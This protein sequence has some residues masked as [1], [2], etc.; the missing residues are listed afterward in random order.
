MRLL[1]AALALAMLASP[2]ADAARSKTSK[3]VPSNPCT[4]E[5][6][7]K[8]FDIEGLKSELMV[9][10][11]VCKDQDRYND[12]MGR[13]KPDLV[14]QER[15]LGAYFKRVNGRASQKAYDDYISNLANVQEQDGLKAGTAFCDNLPDLFDEVMALH[16]S[17][18]LD[19]FAN[20]QAIVQPVA[21]QTCT[22][23]AAPPATV[24]RV[25]HTRKAAKAG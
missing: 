10:A 6:D 11:L 18:E 8:A 1:S 12:F 2:M 19:E 13:Y 24:R 15:A 25:K 17:D 22:T 4:Y 14:V 3:A 5:G 21:F 9:T 7:R 20:S 23:V 16:N